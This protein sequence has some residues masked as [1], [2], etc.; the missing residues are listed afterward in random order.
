MQDLFTCF[1][2]GS[3]NS[4]LLFFSCCCT[5]TGVS[6]KLEMYEEVLSFTPYVLSFTSPMSGG[7][8]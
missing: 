2:T 4:L 5:V 1:L 6:S 8:T 3:G 7:F